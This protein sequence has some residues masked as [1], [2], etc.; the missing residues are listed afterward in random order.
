MDYGHA[1]KLRTIELLLRESTI[2][3][4]KLYLQKLI[5]WKLVTFLCDL[6]YNMAIK[7]ITKRV[8]AKHA[9]DRE[10]PKR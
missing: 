4:R 8:V 6:P 5:L 10:E 1:Y 9:I 7:A 3:V 2:D